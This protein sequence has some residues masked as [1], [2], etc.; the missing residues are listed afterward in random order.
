MTWMQV[1]EYLNRDDRCVVPLGCTERYA[2]GIAVEKAREV[3]V[4][5][6]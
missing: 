4:E 5:G 6:W 2:W 3:L 1:E